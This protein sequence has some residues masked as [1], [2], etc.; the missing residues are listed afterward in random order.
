M[1]NYTK[2]AFDNAPIGLVMAEN[3]I[4]KRAVI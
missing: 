3:R 2:L 1:V 4:I